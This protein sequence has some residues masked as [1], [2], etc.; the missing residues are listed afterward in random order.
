MAPL[1]KSTK[2][3]KMLQIHKE[4]YESNPKFCKQKCRS[5]AP[6]TLSI[7]IVLVMEISLQDMSYKCRHKK[8]QLS[9]LKKRARLESNVGYPISKCYWKFH[10]YNGMPKT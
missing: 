7:S 5:N 4:N 10:V 6:S 9:F 1:E 8:V 2:K 3:L